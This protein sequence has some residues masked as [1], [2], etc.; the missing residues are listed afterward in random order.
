MKKLCCIA[1]FV[2]AVFAFASVSTAAEKMSQSTFDKLLKNVEAGDAEA[3]YI[4]GSMCYVGEGVKQDYEQT[5]YWFKKAAEQGHAK[6]QYFLG[7]MYEKGE[8]IKQDYEQAEYWYKKP[9]NRISLKPSS[10]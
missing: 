1:V 2:L 10:N 4:L 3:Q 8:G 6:S 7:S 9:Q 5:F